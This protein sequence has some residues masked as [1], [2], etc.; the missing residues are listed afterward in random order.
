MIVGLETIGKMTSAQS[1][2]HLMIL[3][4]IPMRIQVEMRRSNAYSWLSRAL[5]LQYKF[6]RI[7]CFI[8]FRFVVIVHL[9]FWHPKRYALLKIPWE[10]QPWLIHPR[11]PLLMGLAQSS[12]HDRCFINIGWKK[13]LLLPNGPSTNITSGSKGPSVSRAGDKSPRSL[14]STLH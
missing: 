5:Y 13:R 9:S 3:S 14:K 4:L 11:S 1:L 6:L 2:L 8:L 10:Q 12:L 7:L